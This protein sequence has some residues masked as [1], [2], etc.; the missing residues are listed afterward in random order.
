VLYIGEALSKA[1]AI[2]QRQFGSFVEEQGPVDAG[3]L[4]NALMGLLMCMRSVSPQEVE[5]HKTLGGAPDWRSWLA[6]GLPVASTIGQS[7]SSACETH[8]ELKRTRDEAVK[9]IVDWLPHCPE[10]RDLIH[11][12]LL[13]QNVLIERDVVTG[14]FSWK[15]SLFGDFLYD[16][17]A[18]SLWSGWHPGV[19]AADIWTRTLQ[20]ASNIDLIDAEHRHR[21]YQL[22]IAIEHLYWYV[23]TGND[24]ELLRLLDV[25]TPLL[26]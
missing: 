5:W 2:S 18:C 16:V 12:D 7:W 11:R 10:R 26:R 13:H 17:A 24:A 1:A 20:E 23:H 3:Q 25:M 6:R 14:I 9:A 4:G 19:A 21:M 8:T 22:H 15:H